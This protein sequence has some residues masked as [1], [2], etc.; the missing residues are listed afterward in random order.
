MG[1]L[2]TSMGLVTAGRQLM[3]SDGASTNKSSR[4]PLG[5]RGR[6]TLMNPDGSKMTSDD[7]VRNGYAMKENGGNPAIQSFGLS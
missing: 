6:K 7:F 5:P 4:I 1:K 3:T 2:R